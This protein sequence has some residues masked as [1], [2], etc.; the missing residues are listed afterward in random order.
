VIAQFKGTLSV[1]DGGG[2]NRFGGENGGFF[3]GGGSIPSTVQKY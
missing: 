1:T 2:F 3:L